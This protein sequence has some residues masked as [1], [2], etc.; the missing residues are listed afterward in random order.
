M[1][2]MEFFARFGKAFQAAGRFIVRHVSDNDIDIAVDYVREAAVKFLD[3]TERRNF[4]IQALMARLP[5][6]ESVARWLVETA[7]MRVKQEAIE[8]IDKAG[9]A[10]KDANDNI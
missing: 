6:S 2:L 3:N 9:D 7:L 4:V 8:L 1:D 10:A 5:I